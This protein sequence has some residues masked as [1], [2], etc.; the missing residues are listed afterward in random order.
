VKHLKP[1]SKAQAGTD[2][3]SILSLVVSVITAIIPIIELIKGQNG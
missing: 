3:L 2:V 1:I